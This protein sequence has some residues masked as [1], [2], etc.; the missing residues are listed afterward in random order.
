MDLEYLIFLFKIFTC[1][2]AVD[3]LFRAFYRGFLNFLPG[4]KH[5]FLKFRFGNFSYVTT[6]TDPD[7]GISY[8]IT[9]NGNI[10]KRDLPEKEETKDSSV[11]QF[12]ESL[13]KYLSKLEKEFLGDYPDEDEFKVDLV[14]RGE[15]KDDS[16]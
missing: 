5:A 6:F 13:D 4:A 1:I 7:L 14:D 10:I 16:K 15:K 9:S 12:E 3:V 2:Y 11:Q 8:L